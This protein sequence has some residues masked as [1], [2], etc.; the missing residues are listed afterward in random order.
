[1]SKLYNLT[2]L[3]EFAIVNH[4]YRL[5]ITL[6]NKIKE[7]IVKNKELISYIFWGGMTTVVSYLVLIPCVEILKIDE[8]VSNIISWIISVAFAYVVNKL[9]VFK[10]KSWEA[11]LVFREVWQFVS[12]RLV[13][14]L[15]ADILIFKLL[16][17]VCH[18]NYIWVKLFTNVLVVIMNYVF[19]KLVIFKKK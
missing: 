2:D 13:S 12:A 9:F 15:I 6:M 19:S 18:F 7:L 3:C 4:K 1:M 11:K 5:E 16:V 8:T 10:S 14:L 17:D